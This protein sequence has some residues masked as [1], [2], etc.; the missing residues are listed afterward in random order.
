MNRS[1]KDMDSPIVC[2]HNKFR[3]MG[4]HLRRTLLLLLL[5]I[6]CF[7]NVI[8]QQF[9][10][11]HATVQ[12]LPPYGLYLSDYYSGSRDRLIVTLLNRDLEQQQLQARLRVK[13]SGGA[14]FTL[15]SRE[16]ISYPMLLLEPGVPLRL[17]SQDLSPYLLP[18]HILLN[19]RL[20]NGRLPT[21]MT[22]FSVQVVEYH[23]GRVL[24]QWATG[25]AWLD[26]KKPPVLNLPEKDEEVFY[27]E[28]L[29]IRFQWMPQHQG[30]A[31]TE[32]EFILKELPDNGIAPQGAF[33]YGMEI[34]RTTTRFTSLNYTHLEPQLFPNRRY[35]WQVRA[36][37]RD[38]TDEIGMFDNNGFSE[39]G[40]F[41]LNERCTPPLSV[42]A[43]VSYRKL[44]LEWTA[45]P[46]QQAYIVSYRPKSAH[47]L[48]EW[49]EE[50]VF[51]TQTT[52]YSLKPGW[53]YEYRVGSLCTTD[54]PVYSSTA[55]ATIPGENA[56]RLLECGMKPERV[57]LS[58]EPNLNVK[59]GDVITIGGDYPMTV[60]QVQPLGDG[61]YSGRGKTMFT[62]IFETTLALKFD[63]LRIN[64][65]NCQIG[66]AVEA[67]YDQDKSQIANL[68]QLDDGGSDIRSAEVVFPEL[69]VDFSLPAMPQATYDEATGE[70][71]IYDVNGTPQ[72]AEV[73]K[74]A[75]GE[76]VFPFIITD[77][78]G[79]RY[80]VEPQSEEENA[81]ANKTDGGKGGA[82]A[83][84]VRK[85]DSAGT[86]DS[87]KLNEECGVRVR[88][89]KGSGIYAFDD[90]SESWYKRAVKLG[91]YTKEFGKGYIAPWKLVPVGRKDIIEARLETDNPVDAGKIR[92]ALADGTGLPAQYD[93][94]SRRWTIELSSVN[95][96][97]RYEVFA[98]Y[99]S[100]PNKFVPVGKLYV[101]SYQTQNLTV[102]IV[103]ISNK[104]VDAESIEQELNAIYNPVGVTIALQTD[105]SLRGNYS[106][107]ADGDGKL[108]L[109]GGRFFDKDV[110]LSEEMAAL[111]QLYGKEGVCIF[112]LDEAVTADSGVALQ[113]DMPR[114]SRFGYLFAGNSP[115]VDNTFART[116]AHETGHGL[117]TLQHTFDSEYGS[118]DSRGRTGNLMDYATGTTLGAF[119]WN[120]IANN[121]PLTVGDKAGESYQQ[122]SKTS[123]EEL[124]RELFIRGEDHCIFAV[125]CDEIISKK[126]GIKSVYNKKAYLLNLN[127]DR[128][129]NIY[130][131]IVGEGHEKIESETKLN[132]YQ[133]NQ[134]KLFAESIKNIES[135]YLF[136]L[137]ND[138]IV[139]CPASIMDYP[140]ACTV[141]SPLDI[142]NFNRQLKIDLSRCAKAELD[143]ETYESIVQAA[144]KQ[145]DNPFFDDVKLCV[146]ISGQDDRVAEVKHRSLAQC[147]DAD[148]KIEVKIDKETGEIDYA[149][150]ASENY[151]K[152]YTG[153]LADEARKRGIEV[154]IEKLRSQVV[155]EL[156]RGEEAKSFFDTFVDNVNSFFSKRVAG[157]IEGVQ[158]T[159]KIAVNVWDEGELPQ[160]TWYSQDNDYTQWPVYVQF[161]PILGG[162]SD[163]VIDEITEIPMTLKSL[164]GLMKSP[165][166]RE[167]LAQMFTKQGGK[168]LWASLCSEADSIVSDSERLEHFG[169]KVVVQAAS[170]LVPAKGLMKVSKLGEV[171]AEATQKMLPPN[172]LKILDKLKK[173]ERYAPKNLKAVEKFLGEMDPVVLEKLAG[174]D[175]F[176]KVLTDMA[177]EW[178]KFR[179]SK[180][181]LEYFSKVVD[182][183]Q[184]KISFEVSERVDGV[185]R[186]YDAVEK[187][188]ETTIRYELKNWSGWYPATIKSQLTKDLNRLKNL[189][190]LRWV[191]NKTDGIDNIE[192]LKKKIMKTL[193]GDKEMIEVLMKNERL[194]DILNK[195]AEMD[196]ATS[197]DFL[198]AIQSEKVFNNL[199]I[200]AE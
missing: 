43:K 118:E 145:L 116:I 130:P 95:K 132:P 90:M 79:N 199:F 184:G 9:Y 2:Q 21:G 151:L 126:H 155:E 189:E 112:I 163:G 185:L 81:D 33:A 82:E 129:G 17:T 19:G 119:Q 109:K 47:E 141:S 75:A 183:A 182:K 140:G 6:G 76:P 197:T 110:K 77:K 74:N 31:N 35:G 27:R 29:A 200:L 149:I 22:E 162:L 72:R 51:G 147:E 161:H 92:F 63:R 135:V 25:R 168:Q 174:F 57:E 38:G 144:Q 61:W 36:I 87:G 62:W 40:W 18:E 181:Q 111:Q 131:E 85:I 32:Y 165:E 78:E 137:V 122:Q 89:D 123:W 169:S 139:F 101:V 41:T 173:S 164:Y 159:Q 105:E 160:S 84:N 191:F 68:D 138:S 176:E 133:E 71:V 152:Q 142:D 59:P 39:V 8:A 117:F 156:E 186:I 96:D 80:R 179:G 66:G 102:T 103:P 69:N 44:D 175:G 1:Q 56:D 99:E 98:L 12:L 42:R 20:N 143:G 14:G 107:D 128:Q 97:E 86:F 94:D 10:P 88:F 65:D 187:V 67:V 15:Q 195:G 49:T 150:K 45:S 134:I 158:T 11:A 48:Y 121:A 91:E 46:E 177:T 83:L 108:S 125:R 52:I 120:I 194:K 167:A 190:E 188:G 23:T 60:T 127:T 3:A 192:T 180:F 54:K 157:L 50:R 198:K 28:P 93:A 24:S 58:R 171:A 170:M 178:N 34:Y 55:E 154:D 100:A 146:R 114:N 113:G 4:V 64:V 172:T 26:V 136:K 16:E 148:I 13:V 70:L 73:P 7:V 53:T 166:Q 106:W 30:L 104:P 115:R 196:I 193:E 5:L 153:K 124:L 37:A